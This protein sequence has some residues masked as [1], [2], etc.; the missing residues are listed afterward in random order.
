MA[1]ASCLCVMA[2]CSACV[3]L[4]SAASPTAA[5]VR[6]D[7]AGATALPGNPMPIPEM[8][9]G[10]PWSIIGINNPQR[11]SSD[12]NGVKITYATNAQGMDSGAAFKATPPGLPAR[13]ATLSYS[14]FF[15]PGFDWV[16]GGKLPGLCIGANAKDCST[17]GNWTASGGSFRI[18]FRAKGQAIGY[19]YFPLKGGNEGAYNAQGAEYKAVAD[20]S[21]GNTGHGIW[22]KKQK[23]FQLNAGAWN[24][25][26]MTVVLNTPGQADGSVSVAVNGVTRTINGMR[27]RDAATSRISNVDFVSFFG[28][29][30]LSWATPK[31]TYTLY[32]N[33]KFSA[34]A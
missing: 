6:A 3:L 9:Q 12:A 27:W 16:K 28:G 5:S 13:T 34:S 8:K 29:G 11:I 22:S 2:S 15:P 31:V 25:V 14:V 19:A 10:G 24:S 30:D 23:A 20:A 26:S 1:V 21:K 17:G 7:T 32:K 4:K 18:M 33:L